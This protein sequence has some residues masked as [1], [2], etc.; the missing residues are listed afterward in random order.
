MICGQRQ[1]IAVRV[2]RNILLFLNNEYIICMFFMFTPRN[3]VVC[4]L[5]QEASKAD[6]LPKRLLLVTK[7]AIQQTEQGNA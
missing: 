4:I 3:S 5:W 1:D 7:L 6:G 2:Y